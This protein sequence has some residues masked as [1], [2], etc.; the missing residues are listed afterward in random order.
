MTYYIIVVYLYYSEEKEGASVLNK[1]VYSLVLLDEVV[2]AVDKLAYEQRTSRSG[3][4]NRILAEYLSCPTPEGRIREIFGEMGREASR[5]PSFQVSARPGAAVV[6]IRSALH[7]RYRPSVRYVLEL[8]REY[9][10][11]LGELRVTLRTQ[12]APLLNLAEGFFRF[13]NRL[14]NETAGRLFPEGKVP[15]EISPGRMRRRLRCPPGAD[16]CTNGQLANSILGYICEF[17][18]DL[19]TYFAD[20]GDPEEAEEAVRRHYL[21]Y[22]NRAA[23]L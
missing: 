5:E 16:K 22:L 14:E 17:D 2:E 23:V 9:L 10:P 1:N 12:S 18:A 21:D 4:I 19:K 13:F 6:T 3:M 20:E 11:L 8:Y 15:C 7:Y